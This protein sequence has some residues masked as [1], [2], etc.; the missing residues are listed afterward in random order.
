MLCNDVRP[1]NRKL[2]TIFQRLLISVTFFFILLSFGN[3]YAAQVKI[4]FTPSNDSRVAGH[5]IYYGKSTSFSNVEDVKDATTYLTPDLQEGTTYYFAA[6]AYDKYGNQS[7]FSETISYKIPNQIQE[8]D[9]N[10]SE[11]T[12]NNFLEYTEDF[13]NYAVNDNPADWFDT[14]ANNSMTEDNRLFKIFNI[15]SNNVFGT[16]STLTNIHS[17]HIKSYIENLSSVEYSGRM[18]I[19]DPNG[20]IGVTFLSHYPFTDTYYRLRRNK[21]SS[22]FH[23]APHPHATAR[24]F[25]TTDSRVKPK[26]NQW[27]RFRI[28][29]RDT[30]VQTEI[31]A[32]VWPENASEPTHWQIEAYD[33]T[34][35][36]LISGTFGVWSGGAGK[37][38]WDDLEIFP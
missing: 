21:W 5:K 28:E 30:G 33:D 1:A 16:S 38:Y 13:E 15:N 20:G 32:K 34:Q 24:V 18:M 3:L 27:Y 2:H 26:A 36:R 37:K 19:T 17:H 11:N 35:N 22:S 6:K 10:E 12:T 4:T 31:L 7:A 9:D 25:G 29:I 23:L 8:P 14:K